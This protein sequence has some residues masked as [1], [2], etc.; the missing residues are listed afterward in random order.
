MHVYFSLY[1]YD[2]IFLSYSQDSMFV[3]FGL[4]MM[5][6]TFSYVYMYGNGAGQKLVVGGMVCSMLPSQKC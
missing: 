2:F 3:Y 4:S 6:G 5:S 1:M